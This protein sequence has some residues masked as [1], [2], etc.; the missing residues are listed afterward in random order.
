MKE[1]LIKRWV[2]KKI[3]FRR[4]GKSLVTKWDFMTKKLMNFPP[5]IEV[6][7]TLISLLPSTAHFAYW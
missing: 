6:V 2:I 7:M 4:K 5:V 3:V 1:K